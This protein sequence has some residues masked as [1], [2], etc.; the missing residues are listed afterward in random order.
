LPPQIT[1]VRRKRTSR[2]YV[3]RRVFRCRITAVILGHVADSLSTLA[4]EI[5]LAGRICAVRIFGDG[6]LVKAG[7]AGVYYGV[8]SLPLSVHG[9]PL[10][11][12]K[13]FYAP[14]RE[15]N[16]S[17]MD[18]LE[19]M[20]AQAAVLALRHEG[21]RAERSR[22]AREL[23][24]SVVQRVFSMRMQAKALR[25]RAGDD[26]FVRQTA[27]ELLNLTHTMLAELRGLIT[28]LRTGDGLVAAVCAH[29]ASVQSTTG[30]QVRVEGDDDLPTE[31]HEDVYRIIQEAL[32]NVVKHARATR[33]TI[34]F[35]QGE[36]EVED[37]GVGLRPGDYPAGFGLVSMQERAAR[38]GATLHL[39]SAA[40]GLLVRLRFAGL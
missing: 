7:D 39:V 19:R 11:V 14:G 35:R 24:D 28:Q 1:F 29:A 26:T 21:E 25:T 18:F 17:T 10:G 33:A 23:Q 36:I 6:F 34:R 16:E 2:D 20:A 40:P 38:C 9:Q 30:L 12:L 22:I 15:P 27:E 5:V 13:A 37:N 3:I 8:V 4:D 31:A 32:H